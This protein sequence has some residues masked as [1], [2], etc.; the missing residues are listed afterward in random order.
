MIRFC[1]GDVGRAEYTLLD[2]DRLLSY[3][4]SGHLDEIVCVYGGVDAEIFVGI[5]TYYSLLYAIS[6]DEAILKEYLIL[7]Q[8]IW[9]NAREIFRRVERNAREKVLLPVLDK[10][11]NLICFAYQDMEANRELWMLRELR[12]AQGALQFS[13]VFPEYR[14]VKIHGFNELAYYFAEY[15]RDLHVIVQVEGVMWEGIFDSGEGVVPEYECLNIYAEGTW[16]KTRNWKENLLRSV[17]VEFECVDKVYEKNLNSVM[18]S[19]ADGGY[20]ALLERLCDEKEVVLRG[21][22]RK[23]QNAYD[24][25]IAHGVEVRCFVTGELNV[26]CM[27]R[28]FGKEIMGLKE[29]MWSYPNAVI[30]DCYA[31]HSA[32]GLGGVD[33]YDYI[34][35]RRNDRYILLRDYVEVPESNLLNALRNSK[36]VLTGD[37]YLCNRLCEYLSQKTIEVMGYLRTFEKDVLPENM[38]EVSD[39]LITEDVMCLIVVPTYYSYSENG[40]IGEDEKSLRI[41]DLR[42][43]HIDNFTDYFSDMIAFVNIEKDNSVKYKMQYLKP[44]NIVLGSIRPYNGTVF[45][46]ALLD[47]HPSILSIHLGDINSHLFWICIR[48][49]TQS[50]E[51]ILFLLRDWIEEEGRPFADCAAF[52]TKMKQ[53]LEH[54]SRV[55]SQE[56]FIMVHIA[57]RSM[58]ESDVEDHMRD[59]IIYWEP[60]HV[61]RE[62][63]EECVKWLEVEDVKCNIINVVRNSIPQKGSP[64]KDAWTITGGVKTAYHMALRRIP[65]EQK[66]FE[67]SDRIIVK[68][69]DLK[70]KPKE[71]LQEICDRWGIQWSDTLLQTTQDGQKVFYYDSMQTVTGFDLKPVYNTYENFF[72]AYDRFRLMC[73]DALW[74]K[75]YGYPY[76]EL[77]QFPRRELQE[78]FLKEFQ[79]ENPGDTTGFYKGHLDLD[80]RI[81]LQ[82]DIRY[83]LYETRCLLS[84]SE[85]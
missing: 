6:L 33:F 2:R 23:A 42:E 54:S 10:D 64:L 17:S 71:T 55:T 26:G 3:F 74:Q 25:L 75:K 72:S 56:L 36:V 63:L 29:V 45:F 41:V 61:D 32:W 59:F 49:S 51:K 13:D 69:E 4:L 46:R 68:F 83:K 18:K 7:D 60:H 5:I 20:V 14:C 31:K 28:L 24:F 38:P 66:K 19:A 35:Y 79:F 8:D 82:D 15:L 48:L 16:E 52:I 22:D 65:T 57:Y 77:D 12:E 70:C 1:D 34:G 76:V 11:K 67:R 37:R 21:I 27:H 47:F 85:E 81:A 43:R 50:T 9:R 84:I 39:D 58:Y 80:D 73:I 78:M 40:T 30:I 53:L 44:K 62:E